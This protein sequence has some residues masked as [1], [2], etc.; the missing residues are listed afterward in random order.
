[1]IPVRHLRRL[2]AKVV[3]RRYMVGSADVR[4]PVDIYAVSVSVGPYAQTAI[5]VVG[6][7]F[8]DDVI[9]GRDVLNH[10]VV[11]LNGLAFM[12]ELAQL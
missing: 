12:V 11:T 10:M 9:I 6:N 4:H 2:E 8:N 3:D 7:R 1:M 5:E